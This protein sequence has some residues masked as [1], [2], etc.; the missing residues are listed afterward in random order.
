M[1]R[2][3]TYL[4]ILIFTNIIFLFNI[5]ILAYE[6]QYQKED[7]L[8]DIKILPKVEIIGERTLSNSAL[9]FIPHTIINKNDINSLAP[10]QISDVLTLSP[11]VNIRDYGGLSGMKTISIRGTGSS[12]TLIMLDGIPISSTQN[13]SFDLSNIAVPIIRDIEIVR[14]GTSAI[15]GGN[16]VG[17]TINLR[18]DLLPENIANI[19]LGIGSFG[20]LSTSISGNYITEN[21][22]ISANATYLQS[23]GNFKF[24]YKQFEKTITTYRENADYNN[25]SLSIAGKTNIKKWDLWTR[26]IYN[27]IEKGVPGAL[28]QGTLEESN[29]RLQENNFIFSLNTKRVLEN[30]SILKFSLSTKI[31]NSSFVEPYKTA[32]PKSM[33]YLKDIGVNSKYLNKLFNMNNELLFSFFIS[34]LS[35]NMLDPSMDSVVNRTTLSLAYH[36]EKDIETKLQNKL[37]FNAGGRIDYISTSETALSYLISTSYNIDKIKTNFISNF[38]HNFRS[39]NFNEM[40]YRNYGTKDLKNETSNNLNLSINTNLLKYIILD[41][42]GFYINTKDMIVSVPKTPVSWSANNLDKVVSKGIELSLNILPNTI[43]LVNN[44]SISYTLQETIDKEKKSITYN[45]HIPYVPQEQ[46]TVFLDTKLPYNIHIGSKCDYSSFRYIQ[47]DNDIKNIL[48][49]YFIANIYAYK[50]L[51]INNINFMLRFECNNIFNEQYELVQNYV[52]PGRNFRIGF[53]ILI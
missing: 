45:K 31:N 40:Y 38:S 39:P 26:I 18:T 11:G 49:S 43:P 28:L 5:K 13:S 10:V 35:G 53:N 46:I 37:Y 29:D 6:K 12:R 47:A 9:E 44:F 21:S 30:L 32:Q 36:I 34:N 14:G 22:Y 41:I 3:I 23:D 48:P 4:F 17:G 42:T 7:T 33:F 24:N 20:E 25:L 19:N 52:M 16:A 1:F 50:N 2:L 15:F 51:L 27:K 8:K